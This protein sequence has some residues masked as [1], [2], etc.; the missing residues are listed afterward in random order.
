MTPPFVQNFAYHIGDT[1]TGLQFNPTTLNGVAWPPTSAT[2][3]MVIK[4]SSGTVVATIASGSGVSI[5]QTGVLQIDPQI[6]TA[7]T[8]AGLYTYE[9]TSNVSGTVKTYFT[10]QINV[11]A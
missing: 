10:G 6:F 7:L 8:V 11:T 3:S 9:I 1:F 2:L 5:P 4:N